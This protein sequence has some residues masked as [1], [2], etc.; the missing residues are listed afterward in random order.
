MTDNVEELIE[1]P[2]C[3]NEAEIFPVGNRTHFSG[4]CPNCHTR[5]PIETTKELAAIE[6]N[7]R[8]TLQSLKE[9]NERLSKIVEGCKN[10]KYCNHVDKE[11]FY[12][13]ARQ[14]LGET[15]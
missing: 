5:G 15:Q 6:W 2:F 10:R 12:S 4:G 11:P 8:P 13:D 9:E 1:C 3:L 14:A 7:T